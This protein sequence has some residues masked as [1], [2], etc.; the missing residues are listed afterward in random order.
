MDSTCLKKVGPRALALAIAATLSAPAAATNGYFLIGYGSKNRALG[1]AS[2]AVG[3]DSL[4]IAANPA[5][6]ADLRMNTMRIDVSGEFFIPRRASTHNADI[7]GGEYSETS[8]ANVFLIPA[9]GGAYKFNRKISVGMAAIGAGSNTRFDQ[10][11]PECFDGDP[12]TNGSRFYNFSC[13][14][15]PTAGVNLLQMQMLPTVAYRLKKTQF[16]GFSLAIGVQSFRAYGLE[17]MGAP[18]SPLNFTSD[19]EHLSNNGNDWSYGAGFR[20]GWLGKFFKK[21][22][23]VGVNYAS[24]VYMSKFDKY[25]GLFAEQG[26]FDI[27]AHY[28]IGFA[29]KPR[30]DLTLLLDI[31]RIEFS[32][33]ASVGNPGPDPANPSDFFPP[34]CVA[35]NPPDPALNSCALG[36]DDGMGFGWKDQTVYKLGIQYEYNPK[37]TLRAGYN[38]GKAPI[39]EDQIAFN[40][41]A[42]AT[43]EHHLTAGFSYRPSPSIEW[44]MNYMVAFKNTI[45]GKTPFYPAGI[46][47]LSDLDFPNAATSMYQHSL[48]LT[49]SYK[50]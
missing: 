18:G 1:G 45:R 3:N 30:K 47:Q 16:I 8:G 25:R 44:S 48:G 5:T 37:L 32:S 10:S 33:I 13:N 21:R 7:L 17:S 38:Y 14:G 39:P 41:L 36:R 19:R 9:M 24:R 12:N 11:L 26:D 27:P 15:G 35:S 42:P 22:L 6:L 31:Q 20:V 28:A 50:L 40:L 4:S 23:S 46:S 29:V 34:G 43:V 2:V 49:F